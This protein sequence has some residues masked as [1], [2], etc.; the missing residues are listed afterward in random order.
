RS[1]PRGDASLTNL[2]TSAPPQQR[3]G[4]SAPAEPALLEPALTAPPAARSSGVRV[5]SSHAAGPVR[6]PAATSASDL[7]APTGAPARPLLVAAIVVINLSLALAVLYLF[8][9]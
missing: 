7:R 9:R 1:H 5:S 6:P 2:H 8:M 4:A 3:Q